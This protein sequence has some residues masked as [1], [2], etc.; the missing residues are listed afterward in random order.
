ME[1]QLLALPDGRALA[2][3]EY[4]VP[5]GAPV[6]FFHGTPGSHL[7]PELD[8]TL[9]SEI[10]LR[11]IVPVRPGYGSSDFLPDRT[12]LDWA[13][14]VLALADALDIERF[15]IWGV[16]GGGPFVL[17]CA[18]KIPDRLSKVALAGSLAPFA[19]LGEQPQPMSLERREFKARLL[20]SDPDEYLAPMLRNLMEPDLSQLLI[21]KDWFL[22]NIREAYRQGVEGAF[23]EDNLLLTQPWG[24]S[25]QDITA[26]V[27]L[28]QGEADQIVPPKHGHYLAEHLP[29]YV[30]HFLPDIGH[31]MPET[32]LR[33]ILHTFVVDS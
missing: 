11:Y 21:Q 22:D 17:A 12:L 19:A 18:H 31:L 16:S 9:A 29:N 1:P 24:F 8:I 23:Y 28:W 27:H 33:E 7:L 25:V 15:G 26:L 3:A 32:Q 30:A 5:E 4:G 13:D 10:G 14:D 2:Y 6:F 20:E